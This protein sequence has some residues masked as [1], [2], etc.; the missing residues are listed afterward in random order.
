MYLINDAMWN[1]SVWNQNEVIFITCAL[2]EMS[3][4]VEV[5]ARHQCD[6]YI[7]SLTSFK[8]NAVSEF[9]HYSQ[10]KYFFL[11]TINCAE[12]IISC[13]RFVILL[14]QKKGPKCYFATLR[15]CCADTSVCR[16]IPICSIHL[17]QR[18]SFLSRIHDR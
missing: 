16:K 4:S 5:S 17:G 9:R 3:F 18:S 12:K 11:V 1:H 14:F 6:C 2:L 8:S 13:A 10:N 7:L 15:I